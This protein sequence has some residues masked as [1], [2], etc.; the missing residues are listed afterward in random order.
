MNDHEVVDTLGEETGW[1][2]RSHNPDF[3]LVVVKGSTDG[4][5][6]KMRTNEVGSYLTYCFTKLVTER[7]QTGEMKGL[8]A[9]LK[10]IQNALHS[11]GKQVQ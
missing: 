3:N 7:A 8:S 4:F 6:S 9:L 1:N 11:K 5:V 10:D 2:D